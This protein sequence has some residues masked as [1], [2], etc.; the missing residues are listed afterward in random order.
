MM[1]LKI[2]S[3]EEF[4]RLMEGLAD[5]IFYA[6]FHYRLYCDLFK[7]VKKYEREFNQSQ[8]FWHLT[9]RAH[10]EA[11]LLRL[12]RA[13]DQQ[14]K[15]LHLSNFLKTIQDNLDLFDRKSFKDRLMDNPFAESL[16]TNAKKPD[17]KQLSTDLSLVD[18]SNSLVKKLRLI[19]HTAIAHKGRQLTIDGRDFL[20]EQS[21]KHS[22]I[23]TLIEQGIK[24]LNRY[25]YMFKAEYYSK[26]IYGHE[27]YEYV[28]KCIRKD[29]VRFE[30]EE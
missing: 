18:E 6:N 7:S 14:G 22:E 29:I 17:S 11:C 24:I 20:K 8:T 30:A 16:V 2:N 3:A 4:E 25:S 26:K 19:R 23:N 9:F 13:Y 27:D 15:S 5:D 21:F 12:C 1:I 28:L 10:L